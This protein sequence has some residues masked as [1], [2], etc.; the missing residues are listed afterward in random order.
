VAKSK[1]TKADSWRPT[2]YPVK[3]SN[4]GSIAG[5]KP[6]PATRDISAKVDRQANDATG[7]LG[8][9]VPKT[10]SGLVERRIG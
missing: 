7:K 3:N 8:L 6:A 2:P 10:L 5:T 4:Y 9:C 1:S